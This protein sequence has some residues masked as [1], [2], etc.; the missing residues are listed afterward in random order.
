MKVSENIKRM[1]AEV[2]NMEYV[3]DQSKKHIQWVRG[4]VGEALDAL[5]R[6]DIKEVE[7]LLRTALG[8]HF[9]HL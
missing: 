5:E 2:D 1:A 3:L 7:R 6:K 8:R 4:D 9:A